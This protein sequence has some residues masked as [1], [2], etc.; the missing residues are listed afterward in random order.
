MDYFKSNKRIVVAKIVTVAVFTVLIVMGLSIV[1]AISQSTLVLYDFENVASGGGVSVTV[2]PSYRDDVLVG[3]SDFRVAPGSGVPL[4][5]DPARDGV[6]TI[7]VT[8]E[9]SF[10]QG[11]GDSWNI[12]PCEYHS[13]QFELT[14]LSVPVKITSISFET[15][16]NETGGPT[17]DAIIEYWR[18]GK[19]LGCDRFNSAPAPGFVLKP[20]D[21]APKDL[22]LENQ[23]TLLKIRF[24]E[25][26]WG[27]AFT[28]QFRIDTVDVQGIPIERV[29]VFWPNGGE[30]LRT[31]SSYDLR[32]GAPEEAVSFNLQYSIDN[33]AT[34]KT[35]V[36]GVNDR[37]YGWTVP[38]VPGVRKS[39]RLRVIGYDGASVKIGADTSDRPFMIEV[40][41]LDSPNG[42]GVY[43]SDE[44]L[45]IA[46]TTGAT[47]RE[48]D[49]VVLMYT[50]N[51]GTKW[52][53]IDDP[54]LGPGSGNPGN[55]DWSLPEV[56]S[57]KAKCKVKVVLM[58]VDGRAIV[59]E[60]SDQFFTILPLV[61]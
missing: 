13:F 40:I 9:M 12:D 16:H 1:P 56:T 32:W 42:G 47:L 23:P 20:V 44:P 4:L 48:V 57:A 3:A 45:T 60:V 38:P 52:K 22:V 27:A 31:G 28:T 17:R 10:Q 46:W 54:L 53:K 29:Q 25:R 11:I 26:I 55:Y 33:G 41:E 5:N 34:W 21:F 36:T 58:D 24:D 61:P 51:G 14:A 43:M 15:G 18:G 49:H 35:I 50:L 8:N 39:A 37:S 30:I 19:L 2:P 7:G 6:V 59:S